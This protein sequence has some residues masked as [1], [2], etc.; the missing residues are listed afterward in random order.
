MCWQKLLKYSIIFFLAFAN[1]ITYAQKETLNQFT[2]ELLFNGTLNKK[3]ATEF[4]Y[5]RTTGS[6]VNNSNIFHELV[7]SS[8]SGW[9]N[10]YYSPRWKFTGGIAYYDNK[11]APDIGQFDAPEW[12]FTLQSTYF[13]HKIGYTLSTRTRTELRNIKDIEGDFE[14]VFRFRQQVKYLKPISAQL[15]RQGVFYAF[16]SDEIYL[17][18][19]AKVTGVSFFDKNRFN[20]GGGYLIT[21]DLQVELSYLNDYQPRDGLTKTT[22][23]I[24]FQISYNNLIKMVK[25]KIKEV[26]KPQIEEDTLQ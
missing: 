9:A 14:Q 8:F 7:Q 12:R 13:F 11:D 6:T 4:Y 25:K 26:T 1:H 3:W 24:A 20:I 15:L 23:N 22:N 18:S 19:D 16:V 10:Y 2:T 5:N 17:K 21:E